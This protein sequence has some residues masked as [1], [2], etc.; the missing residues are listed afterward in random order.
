MYDSSSSLTRNTKQ[1]LLET[2]MAVRAL[3][4]IGNKY[5]CPCCGWHLR[6][7]T[8]GGPS[9]RIRPSGYCPRCNSK[10]RQRRLWLFLKD[11]TNLFSDHLRLLHIAPNYCFSRR[12][13]KLSNL[14]FVHGDYTDRR[15]KNLRPRSPK[16]DPTEVPFESNNFD[17]IICQHVLE[18]IQE[19]RKVMDELY[20]VLKL[21]GWGVVSSP[22]KWDQKTFEDPAI[23][24]PEERLHAFGERNHVR[25]YGH[26]LKNRLEESGF[27]VLVDY[28]KDIKQTTRKRFGLLEDEDIFYCTKA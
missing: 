1:K 2:L 6:A 24:D 22:I 5:I 23:T 25:I 11:K 7:F 9:L 17:A 14:D 27:K 20:R 26:D 8:W 4:F 3:L 12:F 18:H 21:G 28:G 13:M 16:I 19:D 10:A 15:Y